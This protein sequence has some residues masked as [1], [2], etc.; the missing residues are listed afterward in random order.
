MAKD[1]DSAYTSSS[2]DESDKKPK[3]KESLPQTFGV[4]SLS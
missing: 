1:D 4:W 3:A 2:K